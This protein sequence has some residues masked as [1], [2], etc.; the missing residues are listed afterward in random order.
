QI[1]D[2]RSLVR[3]LLAENEAIENGASRLCDLLATRPCD[4]D[5]LGAVRD[6]TSALKGDF[7]SRRKTDW[8]EAVPLFAVGQSMEQM[9]AKLK[10]DD[11]LT[12][13]AIEWATHRMRK[14]CLSV[15]RYARLK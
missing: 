3:R 9:F 12:E 4:E 11:K 1:R 6:I 14:H 7:T 8:E 10:S 15:G 2:F 13:A 5:L